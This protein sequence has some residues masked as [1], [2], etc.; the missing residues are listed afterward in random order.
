MVTN[1]KYF[2]CLFSCFYMGAKGRNDGIKD[3][4]EENLMLL[5]VSVP[6]GRLEELQEFVE[7]WPQ[8]DLL[9]GDF[10]R[11]KCRLQANKCF[12]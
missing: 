1:M 5:D 2:L 10:S 4:E 3:P 9:G 11:G 12:S 7:R 8:L 6:R